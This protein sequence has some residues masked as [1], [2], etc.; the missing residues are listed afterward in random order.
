MIKSLWPLTKRVTLSLAILINFLIKIND[1]QFNP[2]V[3]TMFRV[4]TKNH[5]TE[6]RFT[7]CLS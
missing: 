1:N 4:D 3:I 5:F 6:W 7:K 2:R